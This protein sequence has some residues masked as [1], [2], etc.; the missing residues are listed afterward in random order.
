MTLADTQALLHEAITSGAD[1]APGRVDGCVASTP[2]LSARESVAIYAN[3]YAG[4][5]VDALRETFPNLARHVGD[6]AFA[7]LAEDY[8]RRH[9]SEHHDVGQVG[10]LLPAFLREYADPERPWLADLAELE[11]A[12]HDAFFAPDADPVGA[13]TLAALGPGDLTVTGLSLHPALR[14]LVLDHAIAPLW[15]A[16]ERGEPAGDPDAGVSPVAV[17]RS[18]FE[19]HHCALT[20]EE[21]MALEGAA[22]G[23]SIARVCAA[24]ADQ[25]V[26]AAAASGAIAS[27]FRE[28]WVVGRRGAG[29]GNG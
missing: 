15:R 11:W 9:P 17:W 3:M 22:R 27:W 6:E 23:E 19:V 7:G 4:R 26:P 25:E 16:L 28:G 8:V 10:R 1:L 14:V 24:F 21:A 20:P 18:G 2:V 12:R 5:L 29:E 13:S